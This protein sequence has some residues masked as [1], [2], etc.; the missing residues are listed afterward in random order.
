MAYT[1]CDMLQGGRLSE[2]V[3]DDT[4]GRQWTV[5]ETPV[6]AGAARDSSRPPATA[7]WVTFR[8]EG[9]EIGGSSATHVTDMTDDELLTLL[10]DMIEAEQS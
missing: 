6:G 4:R 1:L 7:P 2:R 10:Q 5:T 8:C 9:M 3:I